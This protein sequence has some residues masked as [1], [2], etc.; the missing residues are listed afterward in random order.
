MIQLCVIFSDDDKAKQNL[1]DCCKGYY[2]RMLIAHGPLNPRVQLAKKW[3][4]RK[5]SKAEMRALAEQANEDH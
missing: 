1:H 2:D 5:P 4:T 3:L